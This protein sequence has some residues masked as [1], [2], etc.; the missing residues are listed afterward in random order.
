MQH[1]APVEFSKILRIGKELCL[2]YS[3]KVLFH[4][5]G[6]NYIF[7]RNALPILAENDCVRPVRLPRRAPCPHPAGVQQAA[8]IVKPAAFEYHAPASV[9]E[10]LKLLAAYGDEAR[11]LAGGQSLVP[12]MA[13][14]LAR[15]AH[16][17]DINRIARIERPTVSAGRLRIP[18][19][20][21]HIDFE[22]LAV[23]GPLAPLLG[24]LAGR[25][26][27]LPVRLRGTFCGAV[28]HGETD[29]DWAVMA[30]DQARASG[31]E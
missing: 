23:P 13:T 19:L 9:E 4:L 7:L 16:V 1:H 30:R 29:L 25:I 18:P 5:I 6:M 15:P 3:V 10:A 14:R 26:A 22:T 8:R 11:V 21:R 31:L 2:G 24:H 12:A 27:H 28:A 20:M 17:I